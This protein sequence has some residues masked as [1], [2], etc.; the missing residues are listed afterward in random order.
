[1][2]LSTKATIELCPDSA[3]T[4]RSLRILQRAAEEIGEALKCAAD[5]LDAE[6]DD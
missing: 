4:V 6:G 1:M 2:A 5:D 3:R